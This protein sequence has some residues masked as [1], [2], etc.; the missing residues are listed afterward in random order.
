MNFLRLTY[1]LLVIN[2]KDFGFI[3]WTIGYPLVLVTIFIATTS[4]LGGED[5][6]NIEVAVTEDNEYTQV[7]EQIDFITVNE[8]SDSTARAE[9]D[10]ENVTGYLQ[11]TAV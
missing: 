11:K 2:F 5:M 9:L 8:M 4:N 6:T 7:L 1:Y 3:F 10:A